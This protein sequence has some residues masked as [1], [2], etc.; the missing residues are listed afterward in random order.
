MQTQKFNR[1]VSVSLQQACQASRWRHTRCQT[2]QMKL[3]SLQWHKRALNV[4][5][6]LNQVRNRVLRLSWCWMPR[7][8]CCTKI[9]VGHKW[10]RQFQEEPDTPDREAGWE[11]VYSLVNKSMLSTELRS[12]PWTC[13]PTLLPSP[14]LVLLLFPFTAWQCC[15]V[16]AH[17]ILH[18]CKV[19]LNRR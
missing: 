11:S 2:L 3:H 12:K 6:D 18:V 10:R 15:R 8:H 16:L 1:I 14:L 13:S 17:S 4:E 5:Q 9:C 7:K 19:S